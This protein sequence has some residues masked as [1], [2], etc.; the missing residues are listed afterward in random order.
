MS[1]YQL[2]VITLLGCIAFN[3]LIIALGTLY[4]GRRG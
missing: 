2:I 4:G 3:T 1:D